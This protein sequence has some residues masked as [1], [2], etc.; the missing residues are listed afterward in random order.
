MNEI[1]FS[2]DRIILREEVEAFGTQNIEELPVD[3]DER[4]EFE[5]D[6]NTGGFVSL[7]ALVDVNYTNDGD[8]ESLTLRFDQL[9]SVEVQTRR[10]ESQP[11]G[12]LPPV[13]EVD[14]AEMDIAARRNFYERL[15]DSP[16][17]Q[18]A[19]IRQLIYEHQELTREEFDRLLDQELG[20]TPEGGGAN[21]SLVVLENI[22]KEIERHGRG[23]DQTL[24]W[25]G[26]S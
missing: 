9:P 12:N 3:Y 13:P 20:F 17:S 11:T 18:P 7:G 14:T 8:I 2:G 21:M 10:R 15:R 1:E 19:K 5:L 4:D 16:D 23:D 25:V 26:A 24:A 22:T 6:I